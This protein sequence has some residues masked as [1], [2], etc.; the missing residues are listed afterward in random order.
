MNPESLEDVYEN[1][2]IAAFQMVIAILNFNWICEY[3]SLLGY[4]ASIT[5]LE[6]YL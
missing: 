1:K 6:V 5:N 2:D 4:Q 3:Y